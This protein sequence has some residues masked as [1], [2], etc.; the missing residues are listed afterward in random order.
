VTMEESGVSKRLSVRFEDVDENGAIRG[1]E[2][3]PQQP[4]SGRRGRDAA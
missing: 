4:A 1:A 3:K 2:T